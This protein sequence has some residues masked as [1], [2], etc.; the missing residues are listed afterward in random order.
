MPPRA[1]QKRKQDDGPYALSG[2]KRNT[3]A[4]SH[5]SS[6]YPSREQRERDGYG[7]TVGRDRDRDYVNGSGYDKHG[8]SS[9]Y[10]KEMYPYAASGGANGGAANK[11]RKIDPGAGNNLG[12]S[13]YYTNGTA[14]VPN[15]LVRGEEGPLL[16]VCNKLLRC[17][18]R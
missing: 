5:A 10:E 17:S 18:N 4:A 7:G 8:N 6:P 16:T 2:L 15:G 14:G 13:A 3:G 12:N 11:R 9:A 1:A